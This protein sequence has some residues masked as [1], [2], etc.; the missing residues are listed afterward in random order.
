MARKTKREPDI[1]LLQEFLL[2]VLLA[3]AG[4]D[5]T[6]LPVVKDSQVFKNPEQFATLGRGANVFT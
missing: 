3:S 5:T 4:V 6:S 1:G 2:R